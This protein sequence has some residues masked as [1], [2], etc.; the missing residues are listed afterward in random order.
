M[1]EQ[2]TNTTRSPWLF[3]PT[4]YFMQ[5]VPYVVIVNVSAAMYTSL[6]FPPPR[7]ACGPA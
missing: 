1:M 5:G 6:G 7:W 4:L 3:V 2:H